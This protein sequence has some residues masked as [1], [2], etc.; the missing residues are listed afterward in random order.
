M[1]SKFGKWKNIWGQKNELYERSQRVYYQ[2][3]E[4]K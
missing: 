1:I 4:Q 2:Q 3:I